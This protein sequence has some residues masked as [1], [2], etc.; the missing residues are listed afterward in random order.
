[1]QDRENHSRAYLAAVHF[2][3]RDLSHLF[4]HLPSTPYTAIEAILRLHFSFRPLARSLTVS[5]LLAS[6]SLFPA[7]AQQAPQKPTEK[8]DLKASTPAEPQNPAQFELLETKFRFEANG[9]SRKEVRARVHINSELGVRQFARLNFDY[10]RSFQSIDIPLVHITHPS[11]GTADILPSAI[12]DNPNP[13]V[14]NAP[15]YQDVRVKSVRILGLEPGDNLEYRVVTATTHH[16]LAPDFWL[17]HSFDRTGV[18]S[19][20]IFEVNLPGSRLADLPAARRVEIRSNT[21]MPA[22]MRQETDANGSA[23]SIYVWES[24]KLQFEKKTGESSTEAPQNPDVALSS[25]LVWGVLSQRLAVLFQQQAQDSATVSDKALALTKTAAEQRQ[26]IEALY[27][28]VSRQISTVDLPLDASG[29]RPRSPSEILSSG[30]ATPEDKF[31]LLTS[32]A[33][34]LNLR[35]E[36]VLAGTSPDASSQLPSPSL[37]SRILTMWGPLQW[38]DPGLEVAPFGLLSPDLRGKKAFR[39]FNPP[40]LSPLADVA[41]P[42]W[43]TVPVDLPYSSSQKV[44]VEATLAADGKLSAKVHYS[45]RGDNELLLRVAFHQS[46]KDKWKELAQLLSLSDGFRGQVTSVNASD[47]YA[48]REP[49]TVDYEITQPKFIDWSKKPVRIP[50]LLP[51]LGLPDPPAKHAQGAATAPIELGT[52]L[53]VEIKMTLRL[54][55]GTDVAAPSGTSVRRDYATYASQFSAKGLIVTAS[56]H[57]NF[58]LRQVPADRA[59]DYNA[60]LRAVLNDQAQDFTLDRAESAPEKPAPPSGKP[61]TAKP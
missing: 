37:F 35:P 17:D 28:L 8:T 20:E 59:A 57:I 42:L 41:Y 52:P 43:F 24:S 47:P 39:V 5:A 45:L 7:S 56:R 44:N 11:G 51:Q 33:S 40:E 38:C 21:P 55:P 32:L 14:V 26:K 19:H 6:A 23:R 29:F 15:A 18:V 3:Q 9:D 49:F 53:E 30:Y 54:P 58:L 48:T 1:M 13:A 10:N 25:F 61:R 4:T 22:A 60:F 27:D 50:A 46:P 16:P 34:S 2:R 31:V 12:T 36:A